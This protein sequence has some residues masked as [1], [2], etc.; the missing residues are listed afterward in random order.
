MGGDGIIEV[1]MQPYGQTRPERSMIDPHDDHAS[2]SPTL[3][4]RRLRLRA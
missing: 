3:P 2:N 4:A 1:S